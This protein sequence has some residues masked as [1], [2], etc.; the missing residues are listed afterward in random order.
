MRGLVSRL[1]RRAHAWRARGGALPTAT[2]AR[3]GIEFRCN[4]CGA[5]SRLAPAAFDR[6]APSCDGCGSNV[7]FR[8]IGRLVVLELLGSEMALPDVEPRPDLHVLGL[9]D[10][11][12]YAVPLAAKFDYENTFFHAEPRLDIT[13]PPRERIGRYDLL[14]ASEVFEHVAP[15]VARAFE[16]A[17]TLLKPGGALV[18]S[19]PFSLAPDTVE[20]FPSLHDWSVV[21]ERGRFR[22]RNRTA[23]GRDETFDDLVFHGGPGSTLEMRLFSRAGLE[24]AFAAAGFTHVRFADESCA[25]FGIAWP[26]PWSVP[27][28]AR[29]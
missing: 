8:A 23:D 1:A 14:I 3:S 19:V 25:R 11:G 7:R 10:A 2:A 22:L 24:R 17:R 27:I 21:R 26:S 13:A 4:L 29:A 9:S 28:V 5:V 18:F 20:H 6:E 16:G 15:P 12:P